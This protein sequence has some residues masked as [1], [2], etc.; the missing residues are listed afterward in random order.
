MV[1]W[2]IFCERQQCWGQAL[3][4]YISTCIRAPCTRMHKRGEVVNLGILVSY[5]VYVYVC[6]CVNV[7]AYNNIVDTEILYLWYGVM[8]FFRLYRIYTSKQKG[9]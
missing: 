5:T 2:C 8:T 4:N 3:G 1:K 7:R 6:V 9:I